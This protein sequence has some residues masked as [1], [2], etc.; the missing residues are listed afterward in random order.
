[1]TAIAHVV[2]LPAEQFVVFDCE[3][4]ACVGIVSVPADNV[5]ASIGVVVVVGGPQYRAG[6]HRQFALLA[7]ELARAGIP[8]FR[9]DYRGMGDS[10][11]EPRTFEAIDGDLGAAVRA[12][13][14]ESGVARVVFWGLCDGASAAFM[15][16]ADDPRIAG[17][18]AVNP[19][20]R[21][22]RGEASVRLK[23]YYLQR[24]FSGDFWRNIGH[25][26]WALR[27]RVGDFVAALHSAVAG[28]QGPSS[29]FLQRMHEGWARFGKPV[30]LILSGQDYTA[31]EFE[32]WAGADRRR[33]ELLLR[34]GTEL[35][36]FADADHTFSSRVWREVV[37]QKTIAWI[38]TLE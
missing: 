20:A 38:R 6:S 36:R 17:I 33:E 25:G 22:P 29:A 27:R 13:Q 2:P 35:C 19:W 23:H 26:R 31:R 7:R 1:M 37:T 16:P 18:V 24:L 15:Y 11:G 5:A 8:V 3:G 4:D 10:E 28:P 9:F 12:L 34:P 21:S 14:R 30:L 32:A